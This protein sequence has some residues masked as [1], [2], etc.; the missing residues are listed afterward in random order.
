MTLER[1]KPCPCCGVRGAFAQADGNHVKISCDKC[2]LSTPSIRFCAI[3]VNCFGTLR[4]AEKACLSIWNRRAPVSDTQ[5]AEQQLG[6]AMVQALKQAAVFDAEA[7]D[8]AVRSY[9]LRDTREVMRKKT[10]KQ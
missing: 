2:G 1:I 4:S 5:T 9:R 7:D 3:A 10:P 8:I 6:S